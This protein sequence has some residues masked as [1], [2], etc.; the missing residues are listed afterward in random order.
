MQFRLDLQLSA[1][2][3]ALI[4]VLGMI[5]RRGFTASSLQAERV[6]DGT[7]Q[8]GML[9]DG[10]RPGPTLAQQ[11]GKVYDCLQVSVQPVASGT[12]AAA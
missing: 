9:I 6:A 12:D 1:A 8:V 3:G 10:H 2:E 5:E 4:R 7:W 11:L